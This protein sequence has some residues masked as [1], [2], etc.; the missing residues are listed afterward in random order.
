MLTLYQFAISHYCEKVRWALDY[1]GLDYST[2]NLL[3]G[4]HIRFIKRI[5][6]DSSVPVLEHNGNYIQNS[7]NIISY[8]DEHFPDKP[9]TP[10]QPDIKQQAHDWE[11]YLDDQIGDHIRRYCYHFLLDHPAVL[12][13]ILTHN[14]PWHRKLL[15]R[16]MYPQVRKVMRKFMVI[17]NRTTAIS[18]KKLERAIDRISDHLQQNRFL[19]GDSFSR[20][21]LAAASLLAP[22]IKPAKYGL[23]WPRQYPGE[24]Q[25]TVD[26]LQ[27]KLHW[28]DE[29][30]QNYR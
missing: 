22:F 1:K 17:N 29:L 12:W 20:A 7:S 8:L 10:S 15:F 5:A 9:L 14:I 11:Q 16:F 30:Y 2:V 28:V 18:L 4:Q 3:P 19:A 27:D 6:P 24:L 25:Q 13:P 21:D 26:R 23:D